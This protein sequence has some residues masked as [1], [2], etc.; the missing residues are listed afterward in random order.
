MLLALDKTRSIQNENNNNSNLPKQLLPNIQNMSMFT[1]LLGEELVR[2]TLFRGQRPNDS[3]STPTEVNHLFGNNGSS[4]NLLDSANVQQRISPSNLR[5]PQSADDLK[6][7]INNSN[8]NQSANSSLTHH[9]LAAGLTPETLAALDNDLI[10]AKNNP[11]I[12]QLTTSI[13]NSLLASTVNVNNQYL[14]N[15]A[16]STPATSATSSSSSLQIPQLD[17]MLTVT[18]PAAQAALIKLTEKLRHNVDR[19][20]NQNLN[21]QNISR[22]VRELLSVH[23]IG[24]RLF[25]KYVLGLSQGKLTSFFF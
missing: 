16:A 24:Q 7:S 22:C 14:S 19:Y 6:H 12:S 8:S 10:M 2:D 15:N 3:R 17:P 1:S 25:A 20:M 23:N 21:T 18:T 11:S 4:N 9:N 5:R 13:S